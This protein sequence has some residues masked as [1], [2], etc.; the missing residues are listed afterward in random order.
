ML[1]YSDREGTPNAAKALV[2]DLDLSVIA[3]DGRTT[4]LP[5]TLN[6]EDPSA[7]AAPG[8]NP[9]DP[10]EQVIVPAPVPGEYVVEVT[11]KDVPGAEQEFF[12]T[13]SFAEV[14]R[15]ACTSTLVG[16]LITFPEAD[17]GQPIQ[18]YRSNTCADWSPA[19][20]ETWVRVK[21]GGNLKGSAAVAVGAGANATGMTRSS[22]V[23]FAERSLTVRQSG[24]CTSEALEAG[25]AIKPVLASSD[26]VA[27]PGGYRKLYTFDAPAGTWVSAR[28]SSTSSTFDSYLELRHTLSGLLIAANDDGGGGLNARIPATS[29]SLR[30]PMDGSYTLVARTIG[31]TTTGEFELAYFVAEPPA[32]SAGAVPARPVNGCPATLDGELAPEASREG[33][34]GSF[35]YTDV[36]TIPAL[37][38]QLLT[39]SV[40][41]TEVDTVIYL[42]APNGRLVAW[43]DDDEGAIGSKVSAPVTESGFWRLEVTSFAPRAR[44]K[45]KLNVE[46]CTPVPQ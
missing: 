27:S 7:D 42:L 12:L 18:L 37:T 43:N 2:N 29:G 38:G 45:Y 26:C 11:A 41:E 21:P 46:G 15:P 40:P 13:W 6:P 1:A 24:P 4:F 30:L 34:R 35:F 33:R 9:R 31:S 36:Y 5:L 23:R 25:N 10:L 19:P 32:S 14:K 8:V 22:A 39:A 17:S 28:M 16:S 3:P 20:A 44:G